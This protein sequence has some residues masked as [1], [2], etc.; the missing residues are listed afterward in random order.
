MQK[1]FGS[2]PKKKISRDTRYLKF[3]NDEKH[4][5]N[6]LKNKKNQEAKNAYLKLLK[7]GY[8]NYEI[9]FNLGFIELSERNYK[10]AINYLK[11]PKSQSK[12]NNFKLIFALVN[13]YL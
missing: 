11:K 2:A 7:S 4:A 6:L 1:G 8:Q 9:F 5:K 10:K 3:F 13:S 12:T